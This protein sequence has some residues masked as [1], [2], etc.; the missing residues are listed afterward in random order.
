MGAGAAALT[1]C[2][3]PKPPAG[4]V[5]A[6]KLPTDVSATEKVVNWANWTAY[7]DMDDEGKTY[8]TLEAFIKETGIKATYTE[9][10]DDNDS[11]VSKVRPQLEAKQDIGKDIITLTDWMANRM[12]RD[13]LVQ[14]L[15][16]I[17]MPNAGNLLPP[18]KEVSFDPGRNYSLTW[19]SGFAGIGYDKERVGS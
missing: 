19:Q 18:L 13:Q 10:I 9:D 2:A 14:P 6:V 16:L 17:Q 7:L 15:E 8:P 1:A 4:G 12:I 5:A 11:Y 3:P